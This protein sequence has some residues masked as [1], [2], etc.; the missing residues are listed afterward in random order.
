VLH[1]GQRGKERAGHVEDLRGEK[2]GQERAGGV[3]CASRREQGKIYASRREQGLRDEGVCRACAS[4]VHGE[5][6]AG[7]CRA[8]ASCRCPNGAI[9]GRLVPGR[10]PHVGRASREGIHRRLQRHERAHRW[11]AVPVVAPVSP[12]HQLH[13]EARAAPGRCR[14]GG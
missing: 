1:G 3:D 13:E 4:S 11:H 7:V 14:I 8:C 6:R 2:A 5:A 9:H 10:E 12:R